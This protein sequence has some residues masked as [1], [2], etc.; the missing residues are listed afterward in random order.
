VKT[1]AA[2]VLSRGSF[3]DWHAHGTLDVN[4][5]ANKSPQTVA[6]TGTGK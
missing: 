3:G 5:S 2:A 6:L 1:A 4:H